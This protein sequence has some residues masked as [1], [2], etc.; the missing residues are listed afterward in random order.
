MD[1]ALIYGLVSSRDVSIRYVGQSKPEQKRRLYYHL[2]YAQRGGRSPVAK[3]IRREVAEGFKVSMLPFCMGQ[4]NVDEVFY[5]NRC[6]QLGY[7]LLNVTPGGDGGSAKTGFKHSA[8]TRLKMSQSAVGKNKGVIR[9]EDFRARV[10]ATMKQR[11]AA[12]PEWKERLRKA[13]LT[14][15]LKQKGQ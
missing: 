4:R 1:A 12:S 5:I 3:W 9:N 2:Y 14:R 10:S 13:S 6:K 8:E 15:W 7:R 11:I